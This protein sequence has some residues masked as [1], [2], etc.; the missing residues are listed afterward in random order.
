MKKIT[1]AVILAG[2]RGTRLL[3]L[4]LDTPKSMVIIAG[5]PFL[6]YIIQLLKKNGIKE[7]VILT[8]YLHEKI[9]KYFGDGEMFG[10]KIKYSYSSIEDETGTRVRKAKHLLQNTFLLLYSDNYWPLDLQ[11]LSKYYYSHR[12]LGLVTIYRNMDNYSKNNILVNEKGYVD[13]YDKER[14]SENLNGIDIGFFILDRKIVDYLPKDNV[15]FEGVIFPILI[16]QKQLSGF[17]TNHK[18]YSLTNIER[19]PMVEKFFTPKKVIFLDRDGVINK[20]APKAD[21]IKN[22]DEF[23]FLPKAKEA[24][25]LLKDKGYEIF[26]ITNQPGIARKIMTDKQLDNIHLQMKNE[27]KKDGVNFEDIYVCRHGWNEGCFCRKPNPGLFFKA[28]SDHAIDLTDAYC[29]G[30]DERDILAGKAAGCKTFLVTK[31]ED[32]YAIASKYL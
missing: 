4:T 8:G 7:V 29:V 14:A 18:Y 23:I 30:D 10:L 21:Y 16:S 28:A 17:I 2:G 1:Q 11:K 5:K 27:L 13:I 9:E 22:W 31:V 15:S 3:P 25:K 19:I 24:L 6:E 20:K 12:T 32:L 26:L